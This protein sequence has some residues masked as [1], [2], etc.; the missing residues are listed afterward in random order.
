MRNGNPLGRLGVMEEEDEQDEEQK[1]ELNKIKGDEMGDDD[2]CVVCLSGEL[3]RVEALLRRGGARRHGSA[4]RL[5]L[6]EI[7]QERRV[8]D[9]KA[10]RQVLNPC[11]PS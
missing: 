9:R 6:K 8:R 3:V 1:K 10:C 5:T 2:S 4:K 11:F 7:R